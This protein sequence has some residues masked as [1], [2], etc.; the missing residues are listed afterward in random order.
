MAE[1][2][3]LSKGELSQQAVEI[4]TDTTNLESY[5][6]LRNKQMVADRAIINLVKPKQ[7]TDEIKWI[8]NE[9][10]VF[11]DTAQSLISLF[12]PRF[13]LPMT[14]NF[15]ADEKIKMNKAERLNIGI[16][17]TL[18]KRQ[19]DT[20]GTYW[21]RDLAYWV[22]LGWY[23][24]FAWVTKDEEGVKFVG[25]IWDPMT[26]YP[27]WNTD[28]LIRCVRSYEVD[29]VTAIAMA[30]GFMEQGLEFDFTEPSDSAVKP[31][32]INY[33]KRTKLRGKPLIENAIMIAGQIVKPLT[34]QTKLDHIPIHVGGI[35]SPDRLSPNWEQRRGEAIIA[36]NRDMYDYD[37]AI[38]SL[39][40]TIIAE[41]TYGN[42]VSKTRTGQPAVKAE[43]IKGYGTVIPLKLEDELEFLRNA[44]TPQDAFVLE[45][46]IA[47]QQNKG[48]VPP[49]VYGSIPVE[50][51]GF[52]I[53][54]LLA[55]VRYKL[56][57]YLN[58]LESITSRVHTDLM[59]QYKR[60]KFPKITLSTDNP[61]SL[62]R[63]M[64]YVEDFSTADVPEHLFVEV[65][66]PITSQFDKT[67]AILNSVQ[68]MQA[69]LL[70]RETLWEEELDVQDTDQERERIRQDQVDQDAFVLEIEIIE[71]LWD[72][73]EKLTAE[74][75]KVQAD[76]LK[77]YVM[78]KEL[79]VGIRKGI[80]TAPSAPGIPPNQAPPETRASPDQ[81]RARLGIPPPKPNRP[82]NEGRRGA[83]VSPTG[84]DLL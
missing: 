42:M 27:Q 84:E 60:G 17:R 39:R 6:A 7:T 45:Q 9:P 72:K 50:L 28:G 8:S 12:P 32:I 10:K 34:V 73:I 38:F 43:D 56:G 83:L 64:T 23:S 75:K 22:L 63:G 77:R 19:A 49:A 13:R 66:I 76:A 21:M 5:Q 57:P 58:A 11:F 37:N 81:A 59:Y 2:I 31:K 74:G 35:G 18:D 46:Y 62:R 25:D 30:R 16:H 70:S 71:G 69:G 1:K 80:P 4:S 36:A 51:S 48:S 15:D 53:S 24:V 52:A 47:Q 26:V 54:Q 68:A 61:Q 79:N 55:A 82:V 33:W 78:Q 44:V 40:A 41:Q 67:Q 3:K 29:K 20:G 65:T 14:I